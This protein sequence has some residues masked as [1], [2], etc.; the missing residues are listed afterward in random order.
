PA[1]LALPADRPPARVPSFR[2]EL[3][4]FTVPAAL[5]RA[6]EAFGRQE[7]ATPFMTLLTAFAALLRRYSNQEEMLIGTPVANRNR[8]ELEDLVG[9]FINTLAIRADLSGRPSFREA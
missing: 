3:H 8:P 4:A 6:L 1:P 5:R 2:G 9:V 7:G